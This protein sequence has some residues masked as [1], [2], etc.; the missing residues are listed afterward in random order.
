PVL[1]HF[2]F[3]RIGAFAKSAGYTFVKYTY[4]VIH[5]RKAQQD[6]YVELVEGSLMELNALVPLD[7][8]AVV[9][10]GA[11][12]DLFSEAQ[13]QTFG[14]MLLDH[15]CSLLATLNYT[16][17]EIGTS[18]T[19]TQGYIALYEAHMQR[20]Q[21]FGIG[22][23]K[24]CPRVMQ[25]FYESSKAVDL[26]FGESHWQLDSEAKAMHQFLLGF[27]KESVASM[28]EDPAALPAFYKWI[29]QQQAT[30]QQGKLSMR[31]GHVDLF[32]EFAG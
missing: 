8:I 11:V 25:A 15:S 13:F 4:P 5:L 23:G 12:F 19:A 14:N 17:M 2:A 28:I 24:E 22:M 18:D 32:A 21:D 9:T 29:E 7:E 3:D 1:Q 27:M 20:P 30:S 31:V 16:D 6:V 26:T 10:A